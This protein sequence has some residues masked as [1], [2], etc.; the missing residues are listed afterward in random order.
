MTRKA[1][2][3]T[4]MAGRLA[5]LPGGY[6]LASIA[7]AALARMLPMRPVESTA[8]GM[9][10]FFPLYAI[11]LMWAFATHNLL[12]MWLWLIGGGL[13][14]SLLIAWSINASGRL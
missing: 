3:R 12:R 14:A 13:V 2:T 6:I 5:M 7:T 9:M 4:A 11:L 10:L 8:T 1:R